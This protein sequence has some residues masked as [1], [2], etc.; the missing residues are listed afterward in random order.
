MAAKKSKSSETT[1]E[2][3]FRDFYQAK[4]FIE[5]S[6]I[7]T[8][9][10]FVSKND[11]SNQGYPDFFLDTEAYSMVVEAKAIYHNEAKEDILHYIS[12]NKI[13]KD[14]VGIAVS[15]QSDEDLLV[16]IFLKEEYNQ[17][18]KVIHTGTQLLSIK[19][20]DKLYRQSK[21]GETVTKEELTKTL[22]SLNRKFHQGNKV[23]DTERSLFFSG[24]M[25]ALR[26]D[27]FR[28]TYRYIQPP[29]KSE[30]SI[31]EGKLLESHNLN[32]SV[33]SAITRQLNNKINN[34]SKQYSWR[35]R[36]SFIRNIDYLSR[37]A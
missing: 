26:D 3:I 22:K 28:S 33:L 24:L 5:K 35:D 13:K 21:Q 10:G 8:E 19:N 31:Q 7:P 11:T 18:I 32:E 1:T 16:S 12:K 15:G 37:P 17:Q 36:F 14:V 34:L 29:S 4:T 6:A 30:S 27:T 2:N 23:K 20:I 9:Y 25:I